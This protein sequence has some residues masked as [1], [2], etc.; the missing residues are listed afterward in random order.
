MQP[1][2]HDQYASLSHKAALGTG[3]SPT[4]IGGTVASWVPP[5]DARRLSA[6][7]ILAAYRD[8]VA[9]HYL[10]DSMWSVTRDEAAAG[11]RSP[12]EKYREYGHAGL[13]IQQGRAAL[14]GDEQSLHVPAAP[15]EQ[16]DSPTDE[17]QLA[18]AALTWLTGW[19]SKE[20]LWLRLLEAEEDALTLGDAVYGIGWDP[21]RQ[22]PRLR[23]FEPG[24][25][26]PV[27]GAGDDD[28][29]PTRVHIAWEE[30]H[31]DGKT[32][33]HRLT[34]SLGPIRPARNPLADVDRDEPLY[35]VS[36]DSGRVILQDRDRMAPDGFTITRR[37]PWDTQP[38]TLTCHF[39]HAIWDLSKSKG[40]LF[41]LDESFARYPTDSQGVR[42]LDVDLHLDFLPVVH[43]P[44][45]AAGKRHFG[46]SLLLLVAQVLDDLAGTDTDLQANSSTVGSSTL[47]TQGGPAGDIQAGPGSRLAMAPGESAT[48][49]DT[50]RNLDALLKY[51][52]HLLDTLS[53][54][55]RVVQAALGRIDASDVPSGVSLALSF[56]PTRALVRELRAVRDEKL[57]LLLK[58]ALRM[59]QAAGQVPAGPT[60]AAAITFGAF[61]PTDLTEVV[62]AVAE[63]LRAKAIS[64]STGVRMLMDAGLPIEDAAEEV[65]RI[66]EENF[67]AAVQLLEATGDEIAVLEYL[68]R[69]APPDPDAAAG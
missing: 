67:D 23:T 65:R 39:T 15:T 35:L 58:M 11:V 48:Y 64:T 44:N 30:T 36:P 21:V 62:T 4:G 69:S 43:V 14:L 16:T 53:V 24:W 13:L 22:R 9:R 10:P 3:L 33:L 45:D 6:Y 38:S 18:S 32:D 12:A 34:W 51:D 31:D 41:Q 28:E 49:L 55:S 42:Q 29:Y 50:S 54:N 61:M 60:P 59:A 7:R 5:A 57:P 17:Q 19:A 37:Y 25:Y 56:A 68:G 1:F 52:E 8:N 47:V 66:R 46:R 20:R 2:V 40:V 26:F 63:L 27:L